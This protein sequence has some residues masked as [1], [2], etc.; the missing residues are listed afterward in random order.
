MDYK[1]QQFTGKKCMFWQL[2]PLFMPKERIAPIDLHS[3]FK[4][5]RIDLLSLILEKY[6]PSDSIFFT[7][8]DHLITKKHA[9]RWKNQ[10]SNS[11]AWLRLAVDAYVKVLLLICQPPGGS[12]IVI[13][14]L[15]ALLFFFRCDALP[16]LWCFP[17]P[18]TLLLPTAVFRKPLHSIL[19]FDAAAKKTTV[20][21]TS[22]EPR[23]LYLSA[24]QVSLVECAS[25]LEKQAA[26]QESRLHCLPARTLA[27]QVSFVLCTYILHIAKWIFSTWALCWVHII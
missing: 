23:I 25:L 20:S 21:A 10:W 8:I 7:A 24:P 27:Q 17:S 12:T 3:L 26:L 22:K 19:L 18:A 1:N 14:L 15:I 13:L 9:I 16:P 5:N 2:F 4:T 11:L 6:W